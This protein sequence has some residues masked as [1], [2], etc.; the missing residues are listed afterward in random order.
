MRF[1]PTEDQVAFREAARSLLESRCGPEVVRAA[2]AGPADRAVWHGLDEMGVLGVLVPE[3]DG[4]LGL[5]EC[6]L[7]PVLEETGW[8]ALPH[9]VV[10]TA[11]VAGP[12]GCLAG[13]SVR[14]VTDL[15]GEIV[16][17]ALDADRFLLRRGLELRV[18]PAEEVEV[19]PVATV[20]GSRRAGRVTAHGQGDPVA[21][22]QGVELAFD[23]GVL[24]VAAQLLGLARRMLD[25]TVGYVSERRQFGSPVGGFQ[26]VKHHLADAALAVEFAAPAIA[27]AAW[28]TA[29]G[30]PN[31]SRDVSMAKFLASEAAET[32]GRASLQ[33]H[34]AI[35]YTVEYDLHLYL[36]RSWALIR[37]WGGPAAHLDQVATAA[38]RS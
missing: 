25:I 29:N 1:A 38:R 34:G 5:D 16:P 6:Y 14:V 21:F 35:G 20:D 23:R 36:K 2:W 32:A 13:G 24:G 11:M 10:E 7:I 26:A 4:G 8:S 27:R 15:G 12:L 3:A 9:P 31:R 19:E 22:D 30:E 18:F 28:S 37:S 17:H 33:C